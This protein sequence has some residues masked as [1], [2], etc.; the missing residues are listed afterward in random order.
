MAKHFSCTAALQDILS[1]SEASDDVM[2]NEESENEA[3][4]DCE[5]VESK[6]WS[7]RDFSRGAKGAFFPP[8]KMV[9]PLNYASMIKLILIY[10]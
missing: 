4:K 3:D 2:M 8:L 10:V 7:T 9:S 6:W 5:I 1:S